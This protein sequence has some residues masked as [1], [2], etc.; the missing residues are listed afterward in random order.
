M[1]LLFYSQA[2]FDTNGV[3]KEKDLGEADQLLERLLKEASDDYRI[4]YVK[5]KSIVFG[6]DVFGRKSLCGRLIK[7][8]ERTVVEIAVGFFK[9][10]CTDSFE[11]PPGALYLLSDLQNP[12]CTEFSICFEVDDDFCQNEFLTVYTYY[13]LVAD[14]PFVSL[15]KNFKTLKRDSSSYLQPSNDFQIS[16]TKDEVESMA[17]EFIKRLS[18][19]IKSLFEPSFLLSSDLATNPK[20]APEQL[21][22]C[23]S[24]GVDSLTVTVL[25]ALSLPNVK[26]FN[27]INTVF[28]ETE[29][30]FDSGSDRRKALECF[31]FLTEK[32]GPRFSMILVNVK[33]S[34]VAECRQ[35]IEKA[36]LPCY[37]VLDESLASVT[38][39]GSRSKGQQLFADGHEGLKFVPSNCALVGSGA[40]ELLGGYARHRTTFMQGGWDS[41]HAELSME[42]ARIGARNFGRDDRIAFIE[43]APIMSDSFVQ[44]VN[45][46]PLPYRVDFQEPR[47]LGEKRLLRV[48]LRNLG[49]PPHLT[50]T[51]KKAMQFGS[52]YAKLENRG[53]KGGDV[54]I[55]INS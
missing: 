32:F 10:K 48:A 25:A 43:R 12:T 30:D 9:E 18:E 50:D 23:F 27:L 15:F 16:P 22:I 21:S 45:K 52:G 44:W 46:I 53:K 3:C 34:E 28:G 26:Q 38:W 40:D 51:P 35:Q 8:D 5:N 20:E 41:L 39:F 54:S 36:M 4:C 1:S 37:T 6:R 17:N 24:G 14:H 33:K 29:K 49:F 42:I 2:N 11:F 13:P 19:A 47:G 7:K 55:E 31:A